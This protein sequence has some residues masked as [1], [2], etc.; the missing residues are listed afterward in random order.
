[1]KYGILIHETQDDVGVA[2]MD[3]EAGSE[4][5][6]SSL[7]GQPAGSIKLVDNVPLGHKV[8]LRDLPQDNQ[9]IEYG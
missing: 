4:I 6:V 7:E 2:V 9:I 8:A 1:M 3:L 5:G